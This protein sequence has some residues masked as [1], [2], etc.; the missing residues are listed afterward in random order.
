MDKT[1]DN[2]TSDG[3]IVV[4]PYDVEGLG[5]DSKYQRLVDKFGCQNITPDQSE[6]IEKLTGKKVPLLLRR[7]K[8]FAHRDLDKLLDHY[9]KG[10]KFYLYTGRGPSS[11]SMHLGHIIPFLFTKQLQDLF[12]VPVIIQI[13]DDEKFYF[14]DL[15]LE[16]TARMSHENIKDIISFGFDP[17]KTFIFRNTQY[18]GHLYP[19]VVEINKRVT[20]NTALGSFGFEGSAN[21]GMI[22][23]SSIQAAPSFGSCFREIFNIKPGEEKD[24]MCLIPCAIDQDPYF[25]LTRD[26]APRMKL[27]KPALLL[28]KFAP[29]LGGIHTKMSSSVPLSTIFLSDSN[30]TI[31]K[32]I[33]KSFSGGKEFLEDHRKYGGN[34]TVDIPYQLLC[35]FLDDDQKLDQ[36]K[37]NYENGTLLSGEM[38]KECFECVGPLI[39][40]IR[41]RRKEVKDEDVVLFCQLRPISL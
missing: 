41:E 27:P 3:N 22:G 31:K 8:F 32:K 6:R 35:Y 34:T 13:T 11:D 36:I 9:E 25:R 17:N 33:N 1:T 12:D 18:M 24:I 14:K 4:T 23:F 7:E 15:S 16:D 19:T 40:D 39:G 30:K 37:N 28:S 38:K 29:S 10:G 5:D 21:L 2:K 20:L 26:I